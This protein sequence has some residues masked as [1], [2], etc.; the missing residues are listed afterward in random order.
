M[1][2]PGDQSANVRAPTHGSHQM[3]YILAVLTSVAALGAGTTAL[4]QN[5][6]VPTG[7]DGPLAEFS[8]AAWWDA[9]ASLRG[10]VDKAW[11]ERC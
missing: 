9:M 5:R 11:P 6:T 2:E 8:G 3:R 10:S 7:S 1:A 4:A